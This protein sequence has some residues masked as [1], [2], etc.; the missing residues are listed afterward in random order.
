MTDNS[1][2]LRQRLAT[3]ADWHAGHYAA[4]D[5]AQFH[6]RASET[7]LAAESTIR[8]LESKLALARGLYR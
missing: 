7:I 5:G 8:A 2:G 6:R 4:D 3:I 1:E